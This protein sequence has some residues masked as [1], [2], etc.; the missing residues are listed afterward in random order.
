M[1]VL[2]LLAAGLPIS[3]DDPPRLDSALE[4]RWRAEYPRAAAELEAA[5]DEFLANGNMSFHY[6]DGTE[7]LTTNLVV[8]ASRGRKLLVEAGMSRKS[9]AGLNLPATD[10]V[11][12]QSGDRYFELEKSPTTK[13]YSIARLTNSTERAK[14]VYLD[15]MIVEL[16]RSSFHVGALSLTEKMN[17]SSFMLGSIMSVRDEGREIVRLAYTTENGGKRESSVVELVPDMNWAIRKTEA[18]YSEGKRTTESTLWID[19]QELPGRRFFPRRLESLVKTPN[20]QI[21]QRMIVEYRDVQLGSVPNDVFKLTAY[22]L[23]DIPDRPAPRRSVFTWSNP[24][25]WLTFAAAVACFTILWR[26]RSR[27]AAAI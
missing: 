10:R 26:M 14:N 13:N 5:A 21:Y 15:G 3:S 18:L 2:I 16:S 7:Q 9:P 1:F 12:C 4:A 6:F 23:P 20:P 27:S 25:L 11:A 8:A 22:G 19:Y 17:Q 24:L